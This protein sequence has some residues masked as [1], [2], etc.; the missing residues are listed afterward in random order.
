MRCIALINQKGGVGKT[1]T[2]ANL[3]AALALAGK[4]VVV[5]DLDPQA[6]LTLYLGIAVPLGAPST[7][8]VLTGEVALGDA[9]RPTSTP[10]LHILPTDI[11]LAGAEIELSGSEGREELLRAAL[12]AWRGEH[13][14][15]NAGAEPADYVLFDC[16]P[17]LGLLSLNAL[18][19]ADEAFLVVQTHFLALQG[20]SRLVEVIDLVKQRLHPALELSGIV[21]CLYDGR[22]RLAREVLSELRRYF[23]EQVFRTPINANVKLAESPSFGKTIFEY[24]PESVG[25]RDFAALAHEVMAREAR[26]ETRVALDASRPVSE[27]ASEPAPA[28]EPAACEAEDGA[29]APGDVLVPAPPRA[30]ASPAGDPQPVS[31]SPQRAPPP[32]HE[33]SS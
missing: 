20:M 12:E 27:S 18:A 22:M 23:P 17:S 2:T 14:R 1:T 33:R 29:S 3:G 6:N 21:P 4:R 5:V 8:R 16:P 24:A 25:A 7:Y 11:H 15:A 9:L 19:A 10:N 13:A 30:R 26:A 31:A 32:R 28:P